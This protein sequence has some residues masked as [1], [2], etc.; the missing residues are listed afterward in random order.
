MLTDSIHTPA[1]QMYGDLKR[2]IQIR[3]VESV[4]VVGEST[5]SI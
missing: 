2:N 4:S 3:K 5:E 1:P